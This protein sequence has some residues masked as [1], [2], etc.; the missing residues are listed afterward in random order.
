M[1]CRKRKIRCDH[2]NPCSNCLRAGNVNCVYNSRNHPAPISRVRLSQTQPAPVPTS[3]ESMPLARTSTTSG[4]TRPNQAPSSLYTSSTATST[5]PS[6]SSAQDAESLELK[7]RIQD[8]EEQLSKLASKP[9]NPSLEN[10]NPTFQTLNSTISG[11]FHVQCEG[12]S[13]SQQP[14]IARSVTHK[15]RLFGQSHWA[16]NGVLL[17]RLRSAVLQS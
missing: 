2:E 6:H 15:T 4:P 12:S 9:F 5:P 16:V 13:P 17:V 11:T 1:L 10:P 3:Q 8:L 14:A 7:L